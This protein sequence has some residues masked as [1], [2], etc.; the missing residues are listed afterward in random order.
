LNAARRLAA[1]HWASKVSEVTSRA[2]V[3]N[4]RDFVD[5][6][7]AFDLTLPHASIDA[8]ARR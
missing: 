7:K 6:G 1:A 2:D 4:Q 5:A 3:D 8:A